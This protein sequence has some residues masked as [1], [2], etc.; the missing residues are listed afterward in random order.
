MN[1]K[2]NSRAKI[3]NQEQYWD[4]TA[5]K[6]EFPTPFQLKEFEKY[7]SK[8]AKIL[9][10]GCGYGRTLNELHENGFKNLKGIDFS[11]AMIDRGLKSHPYLNLSKHN[12]EK[13]PFSDDE[14]DAVLLIAVLTCTADQKL[15]E[16]LISE[17]SRVLK[18]DGIL[19][20]ND[21]SLNEDQRN[22]DRYDKYEE[23]YGIYGI[24]E[25]PEGAVLRHHSNKYI[26]NL[27]KDFEELIFKKTIY[28]TMNGNKSNGFYYI[29]KLK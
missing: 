17:I 24:F 16:N 12:G 4:K 9:D 2:N 3:P 13:L 28:D 19:Y 25:L 15:Q 26:S 21:Y 22:L 6:K 14:F 1:L 7:V 11:Q 23:K 8:D 29:G 20:I 27:T 5:E 18:K 10:V